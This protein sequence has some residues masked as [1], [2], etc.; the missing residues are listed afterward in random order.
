MAKKI[1]LINNI[2]RLIKLFLRFH[3]CSSARLE[4][5][6]K[7]TKKQIQKTVVVTGEQKKNFMFYVIN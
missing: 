6:N 7:N 1:F 2:D 5:Q 3:N 4:P